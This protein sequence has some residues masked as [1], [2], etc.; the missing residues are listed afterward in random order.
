MAF[1]RCFSHGAL[2]EVWPGVIHSLL[3]YA[4]SRADAMRNMRL[5]TIGENV[6]EKGKPRPMRVFRLKRWAPE[7]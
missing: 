7:R 1:G 4:V 3:G 2:V 6:P 5:R